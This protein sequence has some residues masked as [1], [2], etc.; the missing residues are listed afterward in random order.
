MAD[1]FLVIDG[2]KIDFKGLRNLKIN[3][4]FD[5]RYFS[6]ANKEGKIFTLKAN[7]SYMG[8]NFS[9]VET[10]SIYADR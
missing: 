10:D 5:E 3:H 2:H 6:N 7:M 8:K 1:Q 4:E 9:V